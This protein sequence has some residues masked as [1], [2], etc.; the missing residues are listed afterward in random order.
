MAGKAA[1]KNV[2]TRGEFVSTPPENPRI[3]GK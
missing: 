3:E 2:W 1:A